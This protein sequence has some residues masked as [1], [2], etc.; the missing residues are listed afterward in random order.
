MRGLV[1]QKPVIYFTDKPIENLK[2]W[3]LF[4][5][6]NKLH[7]LTVY[8]RYNQLLGEQAKSLWITHSWLV[9][10]NNFYVVLTSPMGYYAGKPIES[11]LYCLI[12]SLSFVIFCYELVKLN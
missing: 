12:T 3:S 1:G 4:Y 8:L 5:T 9:T 10:E 2:I 7:S 6:S 11:A